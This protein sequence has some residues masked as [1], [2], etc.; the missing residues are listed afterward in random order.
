MAAVECSYLRKEQLEDE[1]ISLILKA[2]ETQQKPDT[3]LLKTKPREAQQLS[4]LWDQLVVHEGI[5]YR[6]FEG[7]SGQSS[8]L[9]LVIPRCLREEVLEEAHAAWD[10]E[11]PF[12]RRQNPC[13]S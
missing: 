2:K 8:H 7:S 5:L 4:Q 10:H 6:Q 12:R 9:Q 3:Q 1:T 13:K 11:L